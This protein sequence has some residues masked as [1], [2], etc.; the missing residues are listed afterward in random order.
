VAR[1]DRIDV[2]SASGLSRGISRALEILEAGGVLAHPTARLYG[3]GG[4]VRLEVDRVVARLKGREAD[5]FPLLRIASE[6]AT[7]R[8]FYPHM[9]WSPV[10]DR[11]ANRF[12]PG[13]LTIILPDGETASIAVRVESH[14]VVAAVLGAWGEPIGST[15]LNLTGRE[16]T[17]TSEEAR[18]CLRQMPDVEVPVLMLDAGDLAGPPAS[19][20]V[21]LLGP[22][23]EVLREGAIS[24]TRIEE[25]LAGLEAT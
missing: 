16:P 14:P 12:W 3:I 19:T 4:A 17:H 6:V 22:E 1:A 15:S 11:L 2:G 5:R 25:S 9:V 8:A 23:P 13:P 24:A 18:R 20:L 10:A 21:S 7:L